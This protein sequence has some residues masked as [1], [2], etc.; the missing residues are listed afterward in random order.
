VIHHPTRR[1]A[2]LWSLLIVCI[3]Y[4]NLASQPHRTVSRRGKAALEALGEEEEEPD[5]DA[6]LAMGQGPSPFMTPP[7]VHDANAVASFWANSDDSRAL[8]LVPAPGPIIRVPSGPHPSPAPMRPPEVVLVTLKKAGGPEYVVSRDLNYGSRVRVENVETPDEL[9]LTFEV[10]IV[11]DFSAAR[12]LFPHDYDLVLH[13][14]AVC[15]QRISL[16]LQDRNVKAI[17]AQE[18]MARR[19]GGH[20]RVELASGH[21]WIGRVESVPAEKADKAR[22]EEPTPSLDQLVGPVPSAERPHG[23]CPIVE[24]PDA[25]ITR[26]THHH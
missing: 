19:R 7:I 14:K 10:R 16:C 3:S 20:V 15:Q 11:R 2:G 6:I 25:E 5:K 21:R 13:T 1:V 17:P 8:A 24:R 26:S 4:P 12:P 18:L 9:C 23:S 22:G